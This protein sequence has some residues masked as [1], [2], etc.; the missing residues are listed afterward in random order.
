MKND[1]KKVSKFLSLLLRHRPE[2]IGLKLDD[3]GWAEIDELIGL[4]RESKHP[5]NH[6]L[7]KAVVAN[8]D[9]QRFSI[10]DD[11]KFIRANQ[12]HSIP[13]DLNL[14]PIKPP[15]ILFH[16]TTT[17]FLSNIFSQGLVKRQRQH[18]HLSATKDTANSVGIRHGKPVILIVAAQ[19]MHDQGY[20]FFQSKNG[21]WLT[22]HI[23]PEFFTQ[24]EQ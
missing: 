7:I 24:E 22:D 5:M 14:K 15:E 23:P 6:E 2:A 21:V 1:I 17:R 4:S 12:G 9:K 18:V 13:V 10:S 19:R 8:N 11:G 20:E 16:G 3:C